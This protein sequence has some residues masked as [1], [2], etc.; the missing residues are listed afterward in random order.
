MRKALLIALLIALLLPSVALAGPPK[1]SDPAG[2]SGGGGGNAPG[3]MIYGRWYRSADVKPV[4]VGCG[5]TAPSWD[6]IV[7]RVKRNTSGT[8]V[9][10][11]GP[12][13]P[14]G[15]ND[16]NVDVAPVNRAK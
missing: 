6:A 2:S 1:N 13:Q 7:H 5:R 3:I 8:V 10:V 16:W 12:Y 4:C 9:V 11:R 14:S 15:S